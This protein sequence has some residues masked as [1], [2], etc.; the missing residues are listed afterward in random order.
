MVLK[1][2]EIL[3]KKESRV[4]PE[5]QDFELK[6]KAY[7]EEELQLNSETDKADH[8]YRELSHE[9][10]QIQI[11]FLNKK[12]KIN[13]LNQKIEFI[14]NTLIETRDRI[15]KNSTEEANY[16][17]EIEKTETE[18]LT[19]KS[20]LDILY[21]GRDEVEKEKLRIESNYQGLKSHILT[22]EEELKKQHRHWNHS[23]ER[24]KEL[25]LQ[26][27]EIEIRQKSQKEQYEEKFGDALENLIK[28]NPVPMEVELQL[29]L[30]EMEFLRNKIESL[31]EVNPLAI[32]EHKKEKER[33]DFLKKQQNDLL[34]AKS[35]LLETI[36][37]LNKTAS[38]L[39]ETTF[40]KIND[41]FKGVFGKFF[42]GG[43][44][45]LFL[46]ENNDPLDA[47]IDI[48]IKIKG[49]K[50]STLNLMSAG[51]KTLTAISL[52][53]AIYL[54]KPSPFCI[55][56]EVD[57]PLD[58]VNISRYTH[59]LQQFARNTQFILVTHNKRTMQA[60]EAMYGITMEEPGVS[61][62]V[63]VRFD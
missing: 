47:N 41:N 42:E 32:K 46:V 45:E 13:E 60:A 16:Q 53:F 20:E 23:L 59:A 28:E 19:H 50:L 43:E 34:S 17:K 57:A 33:L 27:Q 62:V 52:L 48:S 31:G 49:R 1:F 58:D 12:N 11:D 63:S 35:E 4:S 36:N 15:E 9:I 6:K 29:V 5:I 10:Q 39:F 61:K 3:L 8:N 38:D 56:D 24:L 37:K 22:Q 55:L 21:E 14:E 18:I 26:I 54:Y 51:E 30:E 2:Y 7:S 25:E 40:N 44:A